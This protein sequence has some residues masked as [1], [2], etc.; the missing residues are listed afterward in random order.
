M[1]TADICAPTVDNS[2]PKFSIQATAYYRWWYFLY[3][4]LTPSDR[5][6]PQSK[7][8]SVSLHRL[9]P[10]LAFKHVVNSILLLVNFFLLALNLFLSFVLVLK[11]GFDGPCP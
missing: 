8:K 9:H 4:L 10:R 5:S 1:N 3:L 2:K 7:V 11:S 6:E